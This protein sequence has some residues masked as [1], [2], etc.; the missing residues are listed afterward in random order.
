MHDN[1]I[2]FISATSIQNSEFAKYMYGNCVYSGTYYKFPVLLMLFK[3]I[4]PV[5]SE[6]HIKSIRTKYRVTSC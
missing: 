3:E 2:F 4:I 6:S 1:G 5:Y